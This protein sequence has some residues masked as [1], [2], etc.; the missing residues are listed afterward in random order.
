M[1]YKSTN[2]D[3]SKEGNCQDFVEH[4]LFKLNVKSKIDGCIGK[5]LQRLKNKGESGMV[6]YLSDEFKKKFKIEFKNSFV[7]FI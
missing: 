6:F 3:K 2:C 1:I 7:I 5:F 4:V